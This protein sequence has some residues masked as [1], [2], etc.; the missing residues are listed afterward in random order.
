MRTKVS[1]YLNMNIFT[2]V[3][4]TVVHVEADAGY[5]NNSQQAQVDD[6]TRILGLISSCNLYNGLDSELSSS[7]LAL[8]YESFICT[9]F[10]QSTDQQ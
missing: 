10:A 7:L 2:T 4:E 9:R 3:H 5:K 1:L 6:K 8:H